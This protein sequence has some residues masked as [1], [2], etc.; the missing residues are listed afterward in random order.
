MVFNCMFVKKSVGIPLPL[1]G[2]SLRFFVEAEDLLQRLLGVIEECDSKEQRKVKSQVYVVCYKISI[3]FF[4]QISGYLGHHPILFCYHPEVLGEFFNS[5]STLL[6]KSSEYDPLLPWL[7]TGLLISTN[8]KWHQRRKLLTPAF[9]FQ[10]LDSSLDVFNQQADLLANVLDEDFV[11]NVKTDD[12][13]PYVQ[14]AALDVILETAMGVSKNIQTNRHSDYAHCIER[15]VQIVQKR[16]FLPFY[17]NDF[18]FRFL[19]E[20]K[21]Y[22]ASLKTLKD[23]TKSVIE[24]IDSFARKIIVTLT[25]PQKRPKT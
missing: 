9:H 10:I 3:V 2:H 17:R 16:Q 1:V 4:F 7:G 19:P 6:T 11:Q 20:Y 14:R 24:G 22:Q 5:A 12:I 13:F 23:F 8:Q 15:M 18:I 25:V 21:E